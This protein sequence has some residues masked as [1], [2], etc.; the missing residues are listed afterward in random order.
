[1]FLIGQKPTSSKD[2]YALRRSALGIIRIMLDNNIGI[3]IKIVIEKSLNLYQ[4]KLIKEYL[5][6]KNLK[7][8]KN[9]LTIE[10]VKFIIERL[11]VYLKENE[12]LRPDIINAVID[13]YLLVTIN[14]DKY[15]DLLKNG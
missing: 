13:D 12:N 4:P 3:A 2:P 11:R 15:C 6:P 7:T 10:I 1:M 5:D 9:L 14:K 8:Q